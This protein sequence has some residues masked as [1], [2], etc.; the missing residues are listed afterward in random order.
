M[1]SLFH[2][3]WSSLLNEIR[4]LL[5]GRCI[6]LLWMIFLLVVIWALGLSLM[7]LLVFI[8]AFVTSSI[9]SWFIVV[10]KRFGS[11]VIGFGKIPW[12]ILIV[13]F[14]LIWCRLLP[15]FSVSLVSLLMVQVFFLILIRL[16]AEFRKAWL[17]YFCRS[18]QRETS[19]DEFSFEV[20]GW[21]PLLPEVHLPRLTGQMLAD[22]VHRKGVSAGGLD[23]WGWRELK[24][25]PL[26][27]F[28]ERRRALRDPAPQNAVE[29]CPPPC[30]RGSRCSRC[31]SWKPDMIYTSS[32]SGKQQFPNSSRGRGRSAM[33]QYSTQ[34]PG[35]PRPSTPQLLMLPI[36]VRM[37]HV[38]EA[39]S[40]TKS[41]SYRLLDLR[42]TRPRRTKRTGS[43]GS[44]STLEIRRPQRS[45]VARWRKT[46]EQ[47]LLHAQADVLFFSLRAED[48][49][50]WQKHPGTRGA[51]RRDTYKPRHG[52]G[53]T[54]RTACTKFSMRTK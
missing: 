34:R 29:P 35:G 3:R 4:F 42:T 17:P 52:G 15:F 37:P 7:L 11:G 2:G 48:C 27:W 6:L 18:G 16:I 33:K 53:E 36:V 24:V 44:G 54:R 12:F 38:T 9:R 30:R 13:G 51:H 49:T 21:L 46:L 14:D 1:V 26:S 41:N 25:L 28:D 32:L 22:V 23:G 20:E 43:L 10:M 19:L 8:G 31:L 5:W 39:A 45:Q 40:L 47:N 50:G